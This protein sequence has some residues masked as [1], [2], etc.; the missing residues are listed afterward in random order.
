MRRAEKRGMQ[1][2]I[3]ILLSVVEVNVEIS[4]ERT[5]MSCRPSVNTQSAF[6]RRN[7]LLL[8]CLRLNRGQ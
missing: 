4:R 8:S 6:E 3:V 5:G 1:V 2:M 7:L